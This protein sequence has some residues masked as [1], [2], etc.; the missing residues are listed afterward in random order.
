MSLRR[1]VL[2]VALG[3]L[4]VPA[5]VQAQTKKIAIVTFD[6]SSVVGGFE[7]V[8]GRPDVAVGA[9]LARLIGSRL[10]AA[11][12]FTLV[13]VSGNFGTMSDPGA[14]AAAGSS[15][16]ADAVLVG[17]IMTYGSQSAT[18]GAT[19]GPSIGGIRLGLGRRTTVAAVSFDARL[20]DVVSHQAL[21]S[22]PAQAT[23]NRS[24]LALF[25]QVPGLIS[26][27]GTIDMTRQEFSNS[28]LGEATNS[29]VADLI[30]QVGAV[31][32]QIGRAAA[33]V[34]APP[35]V[36]MPS[37][38]PSGA[39]IVVGAAISGP[40]M[41][42]PYQFRGSE[43]FRY[44]VTQTEDR[45][46]TTGFYQM[47]LQPA[48]PGQVRMAV[49]G[50][51]GSDSYSSTVTVPVAQAGQTTPMMGM[52]FAQLMTMGPIGIALF[53]PTAWI[54]FG[55]RELTVGDG[56]SNSSGGESTSV[57]VESTCTHAGQNGVLV[58]V[59]QN[60]EVRQESCLSPS[61]ALPLR[62]MVGDNDSRIELLLTEFRP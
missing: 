8:F 5:F 11:G 34:V 43:H 62:T 45:R 12:G 13:E 32:D 14:I 31:R 47:D 39:P 7:A 48:G 41:W 50:Q 28:L 53:N 38:P 35:V 58:V 54:M 10:A 27:D 44:T 29:A 17:S 60:N 59:R 15:V 22:M 36:A 52:G 18:A 49:Q 46:T 61:V 37:V 23:A 2:A 57:R 26:A 30:R 6:Q 56:W 1:F 19:V 24:G 16:G 25:A 42:A 55:G 40:F 51:L 3:G 33:P 21:G 9:G 20:I 4:S